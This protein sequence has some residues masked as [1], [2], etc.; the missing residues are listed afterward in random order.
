MNG[1]EHGRRIR[2][3]QRITVYKE[4]RSERARLDAVRAEREAGERELAARSRLANAAHTLADARSAFFTHLGD[5]HADVWVI[6]NE[7]REQHAAQE[8]RIAAE[9]RDTAQAAAT[10]ARREHER[11]RERTAQIDA[12][13]A[14]LGRLLARRAEESQDQ[15][16]QERFR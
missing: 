10:N 2:Q 8:Q 11:L 9:R 3:A 5:P 16:M 6:A 1:L 15:D 14:A 12:Q 13:A 4:R 7:E